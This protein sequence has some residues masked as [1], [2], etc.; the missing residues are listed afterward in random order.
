M[1]IHFRN[2]LLDS[3][4]NF[5]SGNDPS[6]CHGSQGP[7]YVRAKSKMRLTVSDAWSKTWHK[8]RVFVMFSNTLD[9]IPIPSVGLVY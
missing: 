7:R 4:L 5:Q 2:W 1:V 6:N 8:G 9:K 3:M